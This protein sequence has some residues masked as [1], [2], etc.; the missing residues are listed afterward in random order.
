MRNALIEVGSFLL[1]PLS[2]RPPRTGIRSI[3]WF[4]TTTYQPAGRLCEEISR[5]DAQ[6]VSRGGRR[7]DVP[8]A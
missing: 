3:V 2:F 5:A 7:E 4:R 1:R 6:V 8:D